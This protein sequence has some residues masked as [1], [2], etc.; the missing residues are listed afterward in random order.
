MLPT[1]LAR[2][3]TQFFV[4]PTGTLRRHHDD[5]CETIMAQHSS[6]A[7]SFSIAPLKLPA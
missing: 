2:L 4:L 3:P 1:Q 5:I 7:A 6:I